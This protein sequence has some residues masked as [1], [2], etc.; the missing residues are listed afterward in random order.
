MKSEISKIIEQAENES[1]NSGNPSPSY[2][3]K[4][5]GEF[6]NLTVIRIPTEHM[7]LNH[8]NHRI[9]AQLDDRNIN[10]TE[11]D[12][13]SSESQQLIEGL[14]SDTDEF[15]KLKSQL[16]S[17]QQREPGLITRDG[18][19]INGNTRCVALRQLRKEGVDHAS[20]MDVALLPKSVRDVDILDIEIDIQMVKL[21]NQEY[22]FTNRLLLIHEAASK[23]YSNKEIS[24][25]MD[26]RRGGEKK[27]E[28]HLRVLNILKAIRGMTSIPISWKVFDAKEN[29]LTDLDGKMRVYAA[30]DDDISAENVKYGRILAIL[31]GLNKDHVREIDGDFTTKLMDDLSPDSELYDFLNKH[32]TVQADPDFAPDDEG[33]V[34]NATILKEFLSTDGIIKENGDMNISKVSPVFQ[35]M[36]DN[37]DSVT[38]RLIDEGREK[39]KD[40]ELS[41]SMRKIRT[42]IEEIRVKLPERVKNKFFKPGD[43]N[44]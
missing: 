19:L 37:L 10:A 38:S 31:L 36:E 32:R 28:Q 11:I 26:W 33:Y 23:G 7:L 9:K 39:T 29:H 4:I 12:Y 21:V 1:L 42:S 25:V 43:F 17:L 13:T 16:R 34:N 15:N 6:K 5:G 22:T 20:H 3:R 18:L 41:V 35:L 27:V 14:L 24:K 30:D 2:R 44:Y 40:R 8:M